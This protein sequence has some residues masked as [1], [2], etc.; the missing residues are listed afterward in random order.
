LRK[1]TQE[2]AL[3]QEDMTKKKKKANQQEKRK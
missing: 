1:K 3:G 2:K